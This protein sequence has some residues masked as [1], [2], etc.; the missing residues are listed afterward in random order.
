MLD[1]RTF[2]AGSALAGAA[3]MLPVGAPRA[4]AQTAPAGGIAQ[5]PAVQRIAVG[6]A[7]VTAIADGTIPL[8]PEVFPDVSA[9]EFGAAMRAAFLSPDAYNGHVTTYLVQRG[10]E[11]VLID[12]GG[13]AQMA[14]TL[15]RLPDNLAAAGVAPGDIGTILI[16]HLH[17]DHIGALLAGGEAFPNAE[18]VVREA[19]ITFWSDPATRAALPAEMHWLFD[20]VGAALAGY[21]GRIRRFADDGEV[22]PGI[23]S[24]FL[25]GH[26]PGHTGYRIASGDGLLMWGD[27]VHAAPLQMPNPRVT[28]GFDADPQVA[29]E[30]RLRLLDEVVADRTLVSGTHLP[31][32]GFGHIEKA[33]EGYR[34]VPTEWQYQL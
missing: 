26:T 13:S 2:L 6:D 10:G 1:R 14:P 30:T 19:E 28:I 17:P 32:P 11:T 3:T 22:V 20:S 24:V 15:G 25:P 12:A 8:G 31:F 33:G 9:D 29:M 4:R 18:L 21:E 23:E 5:A 16:T 27:I 7:V 34:F